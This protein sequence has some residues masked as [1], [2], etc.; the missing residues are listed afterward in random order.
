MLRQTPPLSIK[1]APIHKTSSKG[2]NTLI[3]TLG[4][5]GSPTTLS[6]PSHLPHVTARNH[7]LLS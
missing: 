2:K 3:A 4:S 1:I 5:P 7:L 6:S